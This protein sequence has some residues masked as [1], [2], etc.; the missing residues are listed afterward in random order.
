MKIVIFC[1]AGV[2]IGMGHLS[3]CNILKQRIL[4]FLQTNKIRAE[5]EICCYQEKI[6]QEAWFKNIAP[7]LEG[8]DRV[9]IDSYLADYSVYEL[10]TRLVKKV[11]VID[12]IARLKYPKECLILNG[13]IDT[14]S[15]Y[16]EMGIKSENIFAGIE[17]ALIHPCFLKNRPPKKRSQKILICFGGSDREDHTWRAYQKIKNLKYKPVIILGPY[18]QGRATQI[19]NCEIYKGLSQ[20]ELALIFNEVEIAIS[21]GGVILNELLASG[22]FVFCIPIAKNQEYQAEKYHQLKYIKKTNLEN[23]LND[24]DSFK[25]I[26]SKKTLNF[27]IGFDKIL[28]GFIL[29]KDENGESF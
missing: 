28:G 14:K 22:V 19:Q 16:Y 23:I 20:E 24:L 8:V 9:I 29:N 11:L 21:S 5:V 3:R 12:D 2:N 26:F 15:L 6:S 25:P 1:E 4:H 13:G 10:A 17:Y 27:G 18:Y 7:Y